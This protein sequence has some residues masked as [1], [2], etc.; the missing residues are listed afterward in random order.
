MK[1]KLLNNIGLKL[2]SIIIA[3]IL[4]FT[5]VI[6]NNPKDS[7]D[8]VNIPVK[9]INTHLLEDEGKVFE[10]LENSD[11]VRVTVEV[12]KN[13]LNLLR[14]SDIVAEA[15][16]VNLTAVNTVPI[17]CRV[18]NEDVTVMNISLNHDMVR[19]NVEDEARKWVEIKV[20][21]TGEPAEGYMVS[22]VKGDTTRVQ[23][24]GPKS[25][26]D[27]INHAYAEINVTNAISDQSL[28]TKPVFKDA[29]GNVVDAPRIKVDNM[30]T[31]KDIHVTAEILAVKEVPIEVNVSGTPAEGY[32]VTGVVECDPPTVR[33]NGTVTA[34]AGVNKITVPEE[35]LDITGADE[36]VESI[37][38]IR[39][40]LPDGVNFADSGF[41]GRVTATIHVESE[42]TRTLMI[43]KTNFEVQGMPEDIEWEYADEA[44]PFELRISGLY[45]RI[46]SVDQNAVKGTVNVSEWMQQQN[47]EEL[48]PGSYRIPVNVALPNGVKIESQAVI[49]I[50]ILEREEEEE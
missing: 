1:K 10:V 28:D 23:I 34:L 31:L 11:V 42:R 20:G 9:L 25:Q 44:V 8:F 46:V 38:S 26:V 13:D 49:Q 21:W 16:V 30:T 39:R 18:L 29:D 35:E 7:R 24:S 33:I 27:Q 48:E 6:I 4:W 17:N 19:L 37:I 5:V 12:P 22:Q 43:P 40:Y 41:T 50:I 47:L 2:I 14:S 32:L 45:A 3:V 15:D 36:T